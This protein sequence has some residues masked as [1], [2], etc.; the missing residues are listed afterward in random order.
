M[1]DEVFSHSND[2]AGLSKIA[3][4]LFENLIFLKICSFVE[5]WPIWLKLRPAARI[6]LY[7]G[8]LIGIFS[9]LLAAQSTT[10]NVPT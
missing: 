2:D 3:E 5:Q 7:F 10:C 9:T 1:L 6:L 4:R 8:N